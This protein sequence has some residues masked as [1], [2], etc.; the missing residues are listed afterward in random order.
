MKRFRTV[1]EKGGYS[2]RC[3]LPLMAAVCLIVATAPLSGQKNIAAGNSER[4]EDGSATKLPE[5]A[6]ASIRP[7]N[8]GTTAFRLAFTADGVR[9]ENASMLMIIRAAYG[10]F[11]SLDD[12]FYGVP[13]WA[14]AQRFDVEA[15]VD[16]ADVAEF[17]KLNFEK[18]QLM[19]QSLLENRFQMRAHHEV[20]EQPIYSLIVL[21][22]GSRLHKSAGDPDPGGTMQVKRGQ[23]VARDIVISQLITTLT[24]T[25]GRT[26]QD[27]TGLTGKYDL[28]LEWTPDGD[29]SSM[30]AA[31]G[32]SDQP[33]PPS[34]PSGPSIF[35]AIQEQLGLKLEAAKG[36][37]ECLVIDHVEMPSEN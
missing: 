33:S 19:L 7:N 5:F 3:L 10:M 9:I 23:I 32:A 22:N 11:N 12:K 28:T 4:Q 29:G 26:V 31:A 20:K 24:Q 2:R 15:K 16:G 27:K 25:V 14:K 34:G 17:Q 35:T 6:V 13:G 1:I 18:R 37:V 30:P 8:T 21:K 36:P